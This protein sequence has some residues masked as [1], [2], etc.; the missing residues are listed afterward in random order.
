MV[1]DATREIANRVRRG[2][3]DP[4]SQA[5]LDECLAEPVT[6]RLQTDK[7]LAHGVCRLTSKY[8]LSRLLNSKKRESLSRDDYISWGI[9]YDKAWGKETQPST[10][11]NVIQ[12]LFGSNTR[13]LNVLGATTIGSAVDS[14]HNAELPA[15]E[16][17][18]PLP[19]GQE[20]QPAILTVKTKPKGLR[21]GR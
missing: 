17:S 6:V 19:V 21:Y 10:Q 8:L 18:S 11:I 1:S 4:T 13:V 12:N 5:V 15:V 20:A 3:P 9:A 7:E 16:V 2:L 14:S